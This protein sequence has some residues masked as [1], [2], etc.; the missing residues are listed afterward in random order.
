MV[1]LPFK[2]VLAVCESVLFASVRELPLS[3]LSALL[4]PETVRL[5]ALMDAVP[6]SLRTPSSPPVN[7]AFAASALKVIP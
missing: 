1:T 5:S 6:F 2:V 4:S 3:K 7:V